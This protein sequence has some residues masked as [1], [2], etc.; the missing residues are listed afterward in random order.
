M[1]LQWT[2][3]CIVERV[4]VTS[5]SFTHFALSLGE[6]VDGYQV[7]LFW[8]F[9]H[10]E[11]AV[12]VFWLNLELVFV[13]DAIE[14]SSK[15][16]NLVVELIYQAPE[17]G[18]AICHTRQISCAS[19]DQSCSLSTQTDNRLCTNKLPTWRSI[20]DLALVNF[21]LSRISTTKKGLT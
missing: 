5:V 11:W 17:T 8:G 16:W 13:E 19:S 2:N 9:T 7:C 20:F 14:M 6:K 3:L 15:I 1:S 4:I 18:T 12:L 21:Y 10:R